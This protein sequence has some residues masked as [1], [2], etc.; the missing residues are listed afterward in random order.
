VSADVLAIGARPYTFSER[1]SFVGRSLETTRLS[2]RLC[3]RPLSVLQ[4]ASG[5]G[6][7][8]L[9]E[10]GV[11]PELLKRRIASAAERIERGPEEVAL[12]PIP[13]VVRDWTGRDAGF[14]LTVRAAILG[15]LDLLVPR[16]E[17]S[18]I[19]K[20]AGPGAKDAFEAEK[21]R[22]DLARAAVLALLPESS[23]PIDVVT[24]IAG[25]LE[26][27]ALIF[28]QMEE[29]LRDASQRTEAEATLEGISKY[30]RDSVRLLVAFRSDIPANLLRS[31]ERRIHLFTEQVQDLPAVS[32]TTAGKEFRE[33]LVRRGVPAKVD[34]VLP[35]VDWLCFGVFASDGRLRP[36]EFN[37]S[38]WALIQLPIDRGEAQCRWAEDLA[39]IAIG[40]G[41][42]LCAMRAWAEKTAMDESGV[43]IGGSAEEPVEVSEAVEKWALAKRLDELVSASR[44]VDP[45]HAVVRSGSDG[46]QM[47]FEAQPKN[48]KLDAVVDTTLQMYLTQVASLLVGP[49]E[50]KVPVKREA[51][52]MAAYR[53]EYEKRGEHGRISAS[54]LSEAAAGIDGS[55]F[56]ESCLTEL[57][58]RLSPEVLKCSGDTYE[59]THDRLGPALKDWAGRHEQ[60]PSFKVG[61]VHE[62]Y[63][64]SWP[65]RVSPDGS[66]TSDFAEWLA[67]RD[68][69]VLESVVWDSS[70]IQG[71]SGE[72]PTR[73]LLS[74]PAKAGDTAR[75]RFVNASM[76]RT[77]FRDCV[78]RRIDFVGCDLSGIIF[79]DCI[80]EDVSFERCAMVG[81]EFRGVSGTGR[82]SQLH[83]VKFRDVWMRAAILR[84]SDV[85]GCGF[86]ISGS[87]CEPPLQ[88]RSEIRDDQDFG[89]YYLILDSCAVGEGLRIQGPPAG[90]QANGVLANWKGGAIR[91][92][93][94]HGAVHVSD[95]DMTAFAF[96]L[97]GAST[98]SCTGCDL[99]AAV[100]IGDDAGSD[101]QIHLSGCSLAS[102]VFIA[103]NLKRL[104]V[105]FS[106]DPKWVAPADESWAEQMV[107]RA[108]CELRDVRIHRANLDGLTMREECVVPASGTCE[109]VGCSLMRVRFGQIAG[110]GRIAVRDCRLSAWQCDPGMESRLDLGATNT[111]GDGVLSHKGPTLD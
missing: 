54:R 80:L 61:V 12:S 15:Q 63:A 24:A 27:V 44:A 38:L 50:S 34:G 8:S 9:I 5:N 92:C 26:C 25:P 101:M 3:A 52:R 98:V 43:P 95:M 42:A 68:D 35:L 18:D 62:G 49:D 84:E 13:I 56:Y 66:Q 91:A 48:A 76:R 110:E 64:W 45:R 53:S 33:L 60:S 94:V 81:A 31:L 59:L 29:V 72:V 90:G 109:F 37:T 17:E 11:V 86:E 74:P 93:T 96:E 46:P 79:E 83:G 36:L 85:I 58:R 65:V 19:V 82:R 2:D 21:T 103:V 28:D 70:K 104:W 10:A 111:A 106:D 71:G 88:T 97:K 22:V 87:A 57:L 75:V 73:T 89:F 67:E 77:F 16:F 1:E 4:A 69:Y 99:K 23:A 108:R 55:R 78:L 32:C 14:S 20:A 107:F 39:S 102:A 40:S 51:L 6:K 41:N 30:L 7:S 47:E 105:N 100:W